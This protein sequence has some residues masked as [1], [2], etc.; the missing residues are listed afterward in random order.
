MTL[1][2][3]LIVELTSSLYDA[4][5]MIKDKVQNLTYFMACYKVIGIILFWL[6]LVEEPRLA[7][8]SA[9]VFDS[10][11]TRVTSHYLNSDGIWLTNSK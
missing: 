7:K 4:I 5:W 8:M 10:L 2:Q 1:G 11:G 3:C 6:N 9:C